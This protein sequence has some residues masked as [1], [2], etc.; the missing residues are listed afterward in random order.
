MATDDENLAN[1]IDLKLDR[2]ARHACYKYEALNDQRWRDLY[3]KIDSARV[4]AQRLMS[5]KDLARI[6]S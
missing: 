2:L 5:K 4:V 6:N 3:M 1:E